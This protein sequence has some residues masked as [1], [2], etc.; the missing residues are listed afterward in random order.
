MHSTNFATSFSNYRLSHMV[1]I[2]RNGSNRGHAAPEKNWK[3]S[4]LIFWQ[5]YQRVLFFST[6]FLHL[7]PISLQGTPFFLSRHNNM[8]S[9]GKKSSKPRR[10]CFYTAQTNELANIMPSLKRKKYYSVNKRRISALKIDTITMKENT[11]FE[12][13]GAIVSWH[14]ALAIGAIIILYRPPETHH[15][16]EES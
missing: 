3:K 1:G 10:S 5:F 2:T 7:S 9:S 15:R 11:S 13:Q 12:E 6:C 14:C 4:C 8:L 16:C